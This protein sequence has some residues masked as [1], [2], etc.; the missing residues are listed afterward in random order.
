MGLVCPRPVRAM[1]TCY[2][3]LPR[4]DRWRSEQN[5]NLPGTACNI[6]DL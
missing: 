3:I 4:C 2:A 6:L 5:D 1:L